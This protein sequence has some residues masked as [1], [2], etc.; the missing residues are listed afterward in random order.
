MKAPYV[1][2]SVAAAAERFA[3]YI[4]VSPGCYQY[5]FNIVLGEVIGY[6]IAVKDMG[7]HV[8]WYVGPYD[9][10]LTETEKSD[11]L[12]EA[13][14]ELRTEYIHAGRTH[15]ARTVIDFLETVEVETAA[16]LYD[17]IRGL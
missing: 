15:A 14:Q 13:M 3:E 2:Q 4:E 5:E 12:V 1:Y 17:I 10:D 6:T 8:L 7:G 9:A 16:K 11:K